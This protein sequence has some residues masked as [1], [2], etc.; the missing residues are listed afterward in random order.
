MWLYYLLFAWMCILNYIARRPNSRLSGKM[1]FYLSVMPAFAISAFRGVGVGTDTEQYVVAVGLL[2]SLG[3]DEYMSLGMYGDYEPG[4]ILLLKLCTLFPD[5]AFALIFL[6]SLL[7]FGVQYYVLFKVSAI[8]DSSYLLYFLGT[9]YYFGLTGMRQALSVSFV[10]MAFMCLV[11]C[12]SARAVLWTALAFSFHYTALIFVP[13]LLVCRVNPDKKIWVSMGVVIVILILMAP[14]APILFTV[15]GKYNG[16]VKYGGE[17]LVSG[18][19]MPLIQICFFGYMLYAHQYAVNHF[20][21]EDGSREAIIANIG[22]YSSFL[23]VLVGIATMEVN[24]FYRFMYFLIPIQCITVPT[25]FKGNLSR[26]MKF[27]K[28]AAYAAFILLFTAF[29]FVDSGWFGINRYT[30]YWN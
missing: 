26:K 5:P 2:D 7:I 21:F 9:M 15:I 16:Y 1:Q 8:P 4:F 19:M 28:G 10:M 25:V 17:Y 27:V 13:L 24:L 11:K 6:S 29:L 3:Y 14:L 23:G 22:V 18:R 20:K 12:E 30:L